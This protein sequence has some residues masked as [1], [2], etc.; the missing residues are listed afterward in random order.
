MSR[1]WAPFDTDTSAIALTSSAV[2]AT[3]SLTMVAS[4]LSTTMYCPFIG[5]PATATSA[6]F[7]VSECSVL[8]P[9]TLK[10]FSPDDDNDEDDDTDVVRLM[11]ET[12]MLETM[13]LETMMLE[14]MMLETMMLETMMLETM[15]LETMMLEMTD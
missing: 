7:T 6:V 14:T 3:E 10:V 11:L 12:M 4:G 15:M 8:A 1:I 13:M 5:S 9:P 2:I